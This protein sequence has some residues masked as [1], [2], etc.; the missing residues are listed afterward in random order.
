MKLTKENIYINLQGKSKEELTDL[1]EFLNSNGEK[2]YR[3]KDYFIEYQSTYRTLYLY[4]NL[5]RGYDDDKIYYKT[6]VTIQQ[7]KEILQPMYLTIEQQLEKAEAEVKRL[8]EAIEDSKIKVGDFIYSYDANAF[9]YI[10]NKIILKNLLSSKIK[11][12]NDQ[13]LINKLNEL[14]K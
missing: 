14:I 9:Y 13:E 2:C 5:W 7:L 6:E 8:K 10:E 12:I 3:D 11:K 1:W 4:C